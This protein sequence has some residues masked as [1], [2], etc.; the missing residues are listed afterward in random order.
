MR[1]VLLAK[2]YIPSEMELQAETVR[3]AIFHQMF[4]V[5]KP[6]DESGIEDAAALPVGFDSSRVDSCVLPDVVFGEA[7][8]FRIEVQYLFG[9]NG[10]Y[11]PVDFYFIDFIFRCS[12]FTFL[13]D[14]TLL[15]KSVRGAFQN[16]GGF[17]LLI[18]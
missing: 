17:T 13:A 14:S 8:L 16:V 7:M 9:R 2:R 18:L 10:D 12:L 11:L 5:Q 3:F 6:T 1:S 4:L 15:Y